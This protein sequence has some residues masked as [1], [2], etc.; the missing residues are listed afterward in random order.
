[1]DILDKNVED[2]AARHEEKGQ[3]TEKNI[4]GYSEGGLCDRGGCQ[5]Q[6]DPL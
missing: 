3:T 5:R 1:M 2:R 4:N 6:G